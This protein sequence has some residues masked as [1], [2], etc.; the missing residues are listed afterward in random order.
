MLVPTRIEVRNIRSVPHAVVEPLTDGITAFTGAAGVGKSSTF[1][2]L[3]WALYGEVGGIPGLLVQADMRRAGCPDGEPAEATVDFTLNGDEY[4]AVRRLRKRTRSGQKTEVASAELW[5]NGEQQP[6]ITPTKLTEKITSLTGMSGRAFAGAFFIAQFHLPSLAEGTPAEVQRLVEDQTG[7]S[8][9]SRKIDH[10]RSEAKDAQA[11]ADVLPGSVEEVESAQAEVDAA[12]TDG[13][14]QWEAFEVARARADK[15]R[16]TLESAQDE[17]QRLVGRQRAAQQAQVAVAE[18][19]AKLEATNAQVDEMTAELGTLPEVDAAA[20]RARAAALREAVGAAQKAHAAATAAA[21]TLSDTQAAVD[22][23]GEAAGNFPDDL[24]DQVGKAEAALTQ[25]QTGIGALHGEYQRLTR[26]VEAIRESGPDT[27]ACP[28]CA[29]S[30]T[31]ARQVLVDLLEQAETTKQR[32]MRARQEAQQA[33]QNLTRLSKQVQARDHATRERDAAQTRVGSAQDRHQT[34][35][36]AADDTLAT[37]VG[38]TG[39]TVSTGAEHVLEEAQQVLDRAVAD[40]ATADRATHLRQ[41]LEARRQTCDSI[42]QSLNEARTAAADTVPDAAVDAAAT[43][44]A[45]AQAAHTA[46]DQARQDTETTA[47]VAAERVRSAEAARDK[48]QTTLDAKIDAVTRADTLRHAAEVLSALRRDLLADYTATISASATEL[49]QQVGGGDHIGV[50]IDDTFVPRVRL[51]TGDERP[52]RSLS[53]GEKMR[54]ALCLRLGIADQITGSTGAGMVFA[55]EITANQDE[56]TTQ[57]IVDLIRTLGRPMVII[58]HAPEVSQI[59]N[60]VYEFTKPNE[61]TG[62]TT[63]LAGTP[64]VEA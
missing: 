23:A 53:G 4:T 6:Q 9:L 54:A 27:A 41:T 28:T 46:E 36:Q 30:L 43:T 21:E 20:A 59:A 62:T 37:L 16:Q 63:R 1:N 51:G 13:S 18:Q 8:L 60:R 22:A 31:D 7:L 38:L 50:V 15:T 5:I 25:A 48:A 39:G 58:A 34:A 40:I 29:Q 26:A 32:G 35:Q 44:M 55:D 12:Q 64:L 3:L 14:R 2:A 49:M 10:A 17:H 11:Q 52:M 47:K 56:T 19:A 24:D 61:G 33:E 42:Q 57:A 45:E